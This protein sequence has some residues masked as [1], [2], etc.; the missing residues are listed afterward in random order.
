MWIEPAATISAP[1]A[2]EP[3]TV[4]SPNGNTTDWPERTGLSISMDAGCGGGGGA[5]GAGSAAAT[6]VEAAAATSEGVS[7]GF[8]S[9]PGR[10]PIRTG[11]N[12]RPQAA[13]STP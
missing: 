10:P 1:E 2:T 5:D 3:S 13:G 4:T 12:L 7:A 9:P 8:S 11:G 6:A